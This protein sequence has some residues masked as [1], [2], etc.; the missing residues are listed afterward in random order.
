MLGKITKTTFKLPAAA[1][2][3]NKKIPPENRRDLKYSHEKQT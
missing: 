2:Y 1:N 3:T